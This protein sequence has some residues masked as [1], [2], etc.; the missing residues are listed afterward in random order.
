MD[1]DQRRDRTPEGRRH[2]ER[3]PPEQ[4]PPPPPPPRHSRASSSAEQGGRHDSH[5][6][7]HRSG[8]RDY[9]RYNDGRGFRENTSGRQR[10]T[11]EEERPYSE[12]RGG[13]DE[14]DNRRSSDRHSGITRDDGYVKD[15]WR[16]GEN[17]DRGRRT[18]G[19]RGERDRDR[20]GKRSRHE[21]NRDSASGAVSPEHKKRRN[22]DR[23]SR[24]PTRGNFAPT[25]FK[26]QR[27][28]DNDRG[29]GA[30]TFTEIPMHQQEQQP[31]PEAN[32]TLDTSIIPEGAIP[33]DALETLGATMD[34]SDNQDKGPDGVNEI[35]MGHSPALAPD[36]A[37]ALSE[38]A[39]PDDGTPPHVFGSPTSEGTG[40]TVKNGVVPMVVDQ[41]A[42]K[43]DIAAEGQVAEPEQSGQEEATSMPTLVKPETQQDVEMASAADE[44]QPAHAESTVLA[45][46]QAEEEPRDV[47]FEKPESWNVAQVEEPLPQTTKEA[48]PKPVTPEDDSA[49]QTA[50]EAT[51]A[52]LS[53]PNP[54]DVAPTVTVNVDDRPVT[55]AGIPPAQGTDAVENRQEVVSMTRSASNKQPSSDDP[56]VSSQAGSDPDDSLSEESSGPTTGKVVNLLPVTSYG[57][58]SQPPV[59][60]APSAS[61]KKAATAIS[62]ASP[63]AASTGGGRNS[64]SSG[65]KVQTS[66]PEPEPG[67]ADESSRAEPSETSHAGAVTLSSL[68]HGQTVEALHKLV[69][70]PSS[71]RPPLEPP[72]VA[73][74]AFRP[75]GSVTDH[76]YTRRASLSSQDGT[77]SP[78]PLTK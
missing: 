67:P 43:T 56:L 66:I 6:G 35:E 59:R 39:S 54:F 26:G 32:R 40:R 1:G 24:G 44:R 48:P 20:G 49:S 34:T 75:D 72:D 71:E 41:R 4:Q 65:G 68:E 76:V 52:H 12:R 29:R 57:P 60:P 28:F 8:N 69:G 46:P 47:A 17:G 62:T 15:S 42:T 63:T 50:V 61:T 37:P 11:Y 14:P 22:D 58:A 73:S 10:D 23:D 38:V 77:S 31:S 33:V 18:E 51:T 30:P 53:Q 9:G 13:Y 21:S 55:Q 36:D 2:R 25:D 45:Q 7:S 70:E 27:S 5:E 16:A 3:S 64:R 74:P 78:D 19:E